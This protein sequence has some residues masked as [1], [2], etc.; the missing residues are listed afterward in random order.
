MCLSA[1]SLIPNSSV[2]AGSG[3]TL[4][5]TP[6]QRVQV[7]NSNLSVSRLDICRE[8]NSCIKQ[9]LSL[10][11]EHTVCCDYMSMPFEIITPFTV[12]FNP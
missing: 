6:G 8:P 12:L 2:H 9:T 7:Q 10:D 5:W 4:R 11:K 1:E 3:L